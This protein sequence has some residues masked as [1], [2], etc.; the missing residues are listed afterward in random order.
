MQI[1]SNQYIV[2]QFSPDSHCPFDISKLKEAS[3]EIFA[4]DSGYF[5][6]L[7]S[8]AISKSKKWEKFTWGEL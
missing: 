4:E 6:S 1:S 5:L 2:V 7:K 3:S 8:F